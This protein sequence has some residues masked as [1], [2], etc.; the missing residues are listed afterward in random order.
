MNLYLVDTTAQ[1]PYS[2]A[3]IYLR[4]HDAKVFFDY[5]TG[6]NDALSHLMRGRKCFP[7]DGASLLTR[8]RFYNRQRIIAFFRCVLWLVIVHTS[9]YYY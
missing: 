1:L 7:Q 6:E 8:L 9:I 5:K 4:V 2:C 3:S